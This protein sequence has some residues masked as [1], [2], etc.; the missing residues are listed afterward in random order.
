MWRRGSQDPKTGSFGLRLAIFGL[1]LALFG[2]WLAMF[3][4]EDGNVW[5]RLA[6]FGQGDGNE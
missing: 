5:S 3:D 2:Q 1:R 4:I 6:M